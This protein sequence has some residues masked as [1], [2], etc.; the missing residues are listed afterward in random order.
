MFEKVKPEF[1][2]HLEMN[3]SLLFSKYKLHHR[4]FFEN[5]HNSS[6]NTA[7]SGIY[8]ASLD[9]I[10]LILTLLENDLPSLSQKIL[11]RFEGYFRIVNESIKDNR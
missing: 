11:P 3:T 1:L 8:S 4:L 2:M 7:S 6:F 10:P 5:L 9:G